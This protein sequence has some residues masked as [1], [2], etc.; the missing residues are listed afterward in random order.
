[1]VEKKHTRYLLRSKKTHVSL[2]EPRKCVR[3][4][5]SIYSHK[6]KCDQNITKHVNPDRYIFIRYELRNRKDSSHSNFY[7]VPSVLTAVSR[8][9]KL[10]QRNCYYVVVLMTRTRATLPWACFKMARTSPDSSNSRHAGLR[11]LKDSDSRVNDSVPMT[12]WRLVLWINHQRYD[13]SRFL[14]LIF[15]QW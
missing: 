4:T 7:V 11:V 6:W 14:V 10:R 12:D 13:W 3:D 9:L 1:M 5:A 15:F 2:R 8:G